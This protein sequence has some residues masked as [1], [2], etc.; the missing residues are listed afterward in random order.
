MAAI[1]FDNT[2]ITKNASVKIL[3][4]EYTGR[5]G[6]VIRIG[7]DDGSDITSVDVRVRIEHSEGVMVTTVPID[8]EDLQVVNVDA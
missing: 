2:P 1:D 6:K 7:E 3:A 4:G 8:D 5:V